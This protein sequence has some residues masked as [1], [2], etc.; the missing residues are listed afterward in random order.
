M[1]SE[2]EQIHIVFPTQY[3]MDRDKNQCEK[4]WKFGELHK[5]VKY[6][7]GIEFQK[8]EQDLLIF[9]ESDVLLFDKPKEL[10]E[11]IGDN[12]CI[13]FT[14]TPGGEANSLE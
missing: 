12:S 1:L 3:L 6:H 14:A 8:H 2:N 11:F 7:V 9:D 5:R 4:L 13:C 10:N